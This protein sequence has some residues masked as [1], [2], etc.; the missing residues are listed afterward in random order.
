MRITTEAEL[1]AIYGGPME[2][3]AAKEIDHLDR[4]CRRWFELSP[5]ALI[6]TSDGSRLDVSPKGDAPG[7]CKVEDDKHL[8]VPDWPGNNRIDGLTNIVRHPHVGLLSLIPNVKETLRVNGV[9]S[10]HD[11]EPLRALFEMKGRLP[12]TVLRIAVEE[13]FLHCSRSFLRARLWA[14]GS[15]PQRDEL[16]S[17]GEMIRDHSR[18]DVPQL[19]PEELDRRYAD[20]LY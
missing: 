3:A 17:M 15:W 4:H 9:A 19:T 13:V 1:R 20:R 2:I 12:I 10:I 6:A 14:P 7:L 5:F 18:K 16:P 11:D 8:L